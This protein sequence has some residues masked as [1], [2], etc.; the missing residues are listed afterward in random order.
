MDYRVERIVQIADSLAISN[1]QNAAAASTGERIAA[2][3]LLNRTEWSAWSDH[4]LDCV[5]RLGAEWLLLI[6][7]IHRSGYLPPE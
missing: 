6:T 1:G 4:C 5:S 3:L 7:E 2:A